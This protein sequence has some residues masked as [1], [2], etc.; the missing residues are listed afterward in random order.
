MEVP[1]GNFLCSY[2]KDTNMSL[3]LLYKS[4]EQE[5]GTA[6]E[7]GTSGS[8]EELRKRVAGLIWCKFCVHIYI[9]KWENE[10]FKNY[11]KNGGSEDKRE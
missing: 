5:G 2:L 4:I 11:S 6:W 1:K 3:F 9:Y 7:A 8:G 10:T